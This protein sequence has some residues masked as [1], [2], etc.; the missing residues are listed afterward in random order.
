M[1]PY[2]T[3]ELTTLVF[4]ILGAA[5]FYD[6]L[7]AGNFSIIIVSYFL[8]IALLYFYLLNRFNNMNKRSIKW[9]LERIGCEFRDMGTFSLTHS[10]RCPDGELMVNLRGSYVP[11][12]IRM[13]F[14]GK[15]RVFT[16]GGDDEESRRITSKLRSLELKY[17]LRIND[18]YSD[19]E[20][21]E[22]IISRFPF[23]FTSLGD[24]I[25]DVKSILRV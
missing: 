8:F 17:G 2:L 18:A 20:I 25:E 23:A 11:A 7:V 1:K 22:M 16:L 19:G 21:M 3:L 15:F 6:D 10:A 4:V 24:F 13:K 12:S 14:H 9:A 5:Y